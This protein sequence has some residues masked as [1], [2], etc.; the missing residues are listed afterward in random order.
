MLTLLQILE[1]DDSGNEGRRAVAR[2]P[3]PEGCTG[4]ECEG[5]FVVSDI[6]GEVR[7]VEER[8]V[9]IGMGPRAGLLELVT[10]ARIH[11]EYGLGGGVDATGAL[12]DGHLDDDVGAGRQPQKSSLNGHLAAYVI[13]LPASCYQVPFS[14]ECHFVLFI[15][16][17]RLH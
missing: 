9:E 8:F 10:V 12:G 13:P 4:D 6:C 17:I 1:L 15:L 3:G 2:D 5:E 7:D 16:Q 11:D 14:E